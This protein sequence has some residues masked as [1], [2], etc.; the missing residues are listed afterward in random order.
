MIETLKKNEVVENKSIYLKCDDMCETLIVDRYFWK[1]GTD[2]FDVTISINSNYLC[3]NRLS[4]FKRVKSAI[5][6][7]FKKPSPYA[8]IC[9]ADKNELIDFADKIKEL[10]NEEE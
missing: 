4:F 1:D 3:N 9:I 7:I 6:F 10:A 5:R 2:C 8:E